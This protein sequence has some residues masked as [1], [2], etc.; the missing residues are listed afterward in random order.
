MGPNDQHPDYYNTQ[1]SSAL[2]QSNYSGYQSRPSSTQ[3]VPAT[4]YSQHARSNSANPTANNTQTYQDYQQPQ[5]TAQ[6]YPDQQD[7]YGANAYGVQRA[8]EA[9]SHLGSSVEQTRPAGVRAEQTYG[10]AAGSS[11][12]ASTTAQYSSTVQSPQN[13]SATPGYGVNQQVPAQARPN[14]VNSVGFA[15]MEAQRSPV[16][17]NIN[18]SAQ[19]QGQ[20]AQQRVQ[21]TH[22]RSTSPTQIQ[23]TRHP[24]SL[25]SDQRATVTAV[26]GDQYGTSSDNR[27]LPNVTPSTQATTTAP[28]YDYAQNSTSETN[29]N[30][31]Q[32]NQFDQ[33]TTID[34]S[35][36]Y[37]PWPE[38]EKRIEA[39][40][41][42]KAVQD[43]KDAAKEEEEKRKA[44]KAQKAEEDRTSQ[45]AE[46]EL[47]RKEQEERENA[48]KEQIQADQARR[49]AEAKAK[50]AAGS[51]VA[52]SSA[53]ATNSAI[54]EAEEAEEQIRQLM[55]KV[56]VMNDKH[57]TLLAKIWEQERQQHLEKTTSQSPVAQSP[58]TTQPAA[59]PLSQFTNSHTPARS[60]SKPLSNGNTNAIAAPS[61]PLNGADAKTAVRPTG[62]QGPNSNAAKPALPGSKRIKGSTIW[63]KEKKGQLAATAARLLNSVPEN[64][65]RR[66][67]AS[68]I[69]QMLENNPTYIE[70]CEMLEGMGLE[71][72]RASFARGLLQSVPDVHAKQS[73]SS[74]PPCRP[75]SSPAS[76][77]KVANS[78]P[79]SGQ[80]NDQRQRGFSTVQ[81]PQFSP[82]QSNGLS[83]MP[84]TAI[85]YSSIPGASRAYRSPYFN[86]N[87]QP[88]PTATAPPAPAAPTTATKTKKSTSSNAAKASEWKK[89]ASVEFRNTTSEPASKQDAARKRTFADLVDLTSLSDDDMPANKRLYTG[90][91]PTTMRGQAYQPVPNFLPNFNPQAVVSPYLQL[92][93]AQWANQNGHDVQYPH[94]RP[95]QSG[96]IAN[97]RHKTVELA[98]YLNPRKARK[99]LEYDVKTIARDILLATGKHPD[100]LPLNGHLDPL[101]TLYPKQIETYSDLSTIRWD[102]LDPGDPVSLD[103]DDRDSVIADRDGDAD[104]ESEEEPA[105]PRVA[106]RAAVGLGGNAAERPVT[107]LPRAPI[108]GTFGLTPPRPRGRP[109]KNPS[110]IDGFR[111]RPFG[112]ED[113][114]TPQ[115]RSGQPYQ[116]GDVEQARRQSSFRLVNQTASAS[117][118]SSNQRPISTP[119]SVPAGSG[120]GYAQ[121]REIDAEGKPIKKKG[122]PVGWRKSLHQKGVGAF[123]GGSGIMPTK[124]GTPSTA[125]PE[126]KYA[127]YECK[128]EACN[129]KLHNLDTLKRHIHKIHGKPDAKG[130]FTCKWEN[131]SKIIQVVDK[132]TG[133]VTQIPQYH[134]FPNQGLLLEHVDKAH[135]GP[136]AWKLGDGPPGGLSG[137]FFL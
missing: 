101:K 106:V 54:T 66:I 57:P 78:T 72:E 46:A 60:I 112:F 94:Q 59:A 120:V 132:E 53:T 136:V 115:P 24:Q 92:G 70:L 88:I 14:R 85:S 50:K 79:V 97:E 93:A 39:A 122:R 1:Q 87:G 8:A 20:G 4:Q 42:T 6:T 10:S 90:P 96:I 103:S 28:V 113:G 34:P 116:R 128:W 33:P 29:S 114:E 124:K 43:A 99:V 18:L 105:I 129:A 74:V 111:Q 89:S 36:V 38:Y 130:R 30:A 121:L 40:K 135:V 137:T 117:G 68:L 125:P 133:G 61:R 3:Q 27:T 77:S 104:D 134:H 51:T 15:G 31:Q 75:G 7:W 127:V 84:G 98:Q 83:N 118:T 9:L 65:G 91:E 126:V 55:A 26:T 25:Q 64:Q 47:Q 35:A 21:M 131:C 12:V 107:A 95:T 49:R 41:A 44:I 109:P 52:G 17:E 108:K 16:M 100:M 23:V 58:P 80:P 110:S 5:Q 73:R 71:V 19:Y 22:H 63:P 2:A 69:S 13:F 102:V 37:D 119:A 76:G 86:A 32:M 81:Y 56:K 48:N 45:E 67:E 123:A 62:T 11:N 82:A